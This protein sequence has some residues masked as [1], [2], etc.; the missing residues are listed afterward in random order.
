MK[1]VC[2]KKNLTHGLQTTSRV[3]GGVNSLPIL[4]NILFKTD[5]GRLRISGTNLEMA[6]NTWVAGKVEEEGEITI[7]AKLV[8]EYI[9]NLAAEKVTLKTEK[10]TLKIEGENTETHIKGLPAEEFPLIPDTGEEVFGKLDGEVLKKA[11]SEVVFAAAYSEAQPEISGVLFRFSGNNLE[12]A[13]TDRY[14]LAESRVNMEQAAPEEKQIIVPAR[15]VSEIGRILGQGV[16]EI[17]LREGQACFKN[18]ETEI[19]TRLIDGQYPDYKQI[20]PTSFS[21]QA[22]FDRVA[23]SQ[24]IKA[25]SLFAADNNNIELEFLPGKELVVAAASAQVGDSRIRVA[26]DVGGTKNKIIFNYRYLLDCLNILPDEKVVLKVISE[27]A[28]V[29]IAPAK[30]QDF[31]YIVMPIKV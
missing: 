22:E 16:V 31:L 6:V 29:A 18:Q 13:A 10:L 8:S 11:I 15:A 3:V 27:T 9:H 2:I 30:R 14:R 20:I 21:S 1:M 25:A 5:Q 4:N 12:L 17:F 28:P 23:L 24:A 26:G 7:P 19:I